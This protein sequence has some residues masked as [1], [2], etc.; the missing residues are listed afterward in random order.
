MHPIHSPMNRLIPPRLAADAA[1][2]TFTPP[3]Q[4]R[5]PRLLQWLRRRIPVVL[6][7]VVV[8]NRCRPVAMCWVRPPVA[9][10]RLAGRRHASGPRRVTR[11]V[12]ICV[13][14]VDIV[15]IVTIIIIVIIIIILFRQRRRNLNRLI[16]ALAPS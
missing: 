11:A 8:H 7:V 4:P 9:V 13:A 3:A 2:R 16:P 5:L 15:H 1:D 14:A 10:R 12:P 6:V